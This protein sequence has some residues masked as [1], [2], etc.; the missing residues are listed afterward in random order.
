M[1]MRRGLSGAILCTW[2]IAGLI[3]QAEVTMKF[4]AFADLALRAAVR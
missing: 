4:F 3:R 2:S 1:F